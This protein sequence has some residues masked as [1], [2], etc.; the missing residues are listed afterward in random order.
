MT[1]TN[2]EIGPF[3]PL[4]LSLRVRIRVARE[5]LRGRPVVYRVWFRDNWT[6]YS[7]PDLPKGLV[8]ACQ[9]GDAGDVIPTG[10]ATIGNEKSDPGRH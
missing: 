7:H 8:M 9:T 5:V 2:A 1:N 3:S 6:V 10:F 4:A